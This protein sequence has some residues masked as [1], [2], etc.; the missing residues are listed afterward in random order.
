MT[1]WLP[2]LS[3]GSGPIYQ[4]L[5]DRIESDIAQGVL[6]PGTKLPPQRDLAFDIGVTIGTIGRAYAL[7][8]ERGLVSGEVGRGTFV[9]GHDAA[10]DHAPHPAPIPFGGTRARSDESARRGQLVMDSTSAPD[11]GQGEVIGTLLADIAREHPDKIV[12]Y[13]RSM[14]ADWREAGA[15]WLAAD[16]WA[17]DPGTVVP[18]LGVHASAM[19]VIA[20]VTS[21]GDKIAFEQLTYSS[22][23]RSANLI[24]RRS[25]VIRT[26]DFGPVPEDFERL[27]AQQHPKLAFLI[28]SLHNPTLTI[29]PVDRRRDIAEIAR[30]HNV[31]LIEDAIYAAMLDEQ[32][33]PIATFLPERTF[34]VGGLAKT[35]SAGVRGGWVACPA[36]LAARVQVAHKM[37]TGGMS[38]LL[39]E[40]GA[41]LVLSGQA[42]AI[43]QAARDEIEARE[44]IVREAFAGLDMSS[45]K[46]A[47]F[48]WIKLPDPWLSGTFKNVAASEGVLI[49]DEDEF[50]PGRTEQIYHRFRL[51][52]SALARREDLRG[53]LA[54]VR[55][56]I[57]SPNSGY[58]NY[59]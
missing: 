14:P 38:F 27:C 49:D 17:P 11:L 40:L 41:R 57:D 19:A 26:D 47:P 5:A 24:G 8:R 58:D 16:Q 52:F 7:G 29:T 59:G 22:I 39:A 50:K 32:P 23:S 34:Y 13:T 2:S 21:P 4:R 3:D 18:T 20:A 12:D 54:T 48:A 35:V 36:N 15:R 45:H 42:D 46:R 55:R 10:G 28:P 51:G 6:P 44:A 37:V 9:L 53:G 25:I 1:N 56:L 33:T 30:R 43:R 31:W